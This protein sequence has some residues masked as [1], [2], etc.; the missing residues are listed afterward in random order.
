ME[1]VNKRPYP[2]GN[3]NNSLPCKLSWANGTY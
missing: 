2:K 3:I 1:L